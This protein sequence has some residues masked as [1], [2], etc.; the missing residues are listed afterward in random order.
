MATLTL[1]GSRGRLRGVIW[2]QVL[3]ELHHRG[4]V[5]SAGRVVAVRGRITSG[6]RVVTAEDTDDT[7]DL[8]PGEQVPDA[9]NDDQQ[10]LSRSTSTT[11]HG[12]GTPPAGTV[13]HRPVDRPPTQTSTTRSSP[14]T[15]RHPHHPGD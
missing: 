12:P 9:G 14:S 8:E 5:P 4:T 3:T 6:T 10:R 13:D 7:D 2:D 1:E 15:S 11:S